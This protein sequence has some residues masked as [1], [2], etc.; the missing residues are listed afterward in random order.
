MAFFDWASPMLQAKPRE[1]DLAALGFAN[2]RYIHWQLGN[3]TLLQR[4]YTPV[5]QAFLLWGLI[6]LVIFL[7]AQFSTLDW[8]TQAALDTSL[9][10]L[11]TLA[12]LHLSHDWSKREGVLWMGW[13]WAGLMA[14]GTVLTDWAVIQAWGWVLVNLCELWL[15]LCAVGYGISGWGMRSRAL[16]LTGAV[17]GGAIGVLPWC[18]SW[19]F[20]ATG[21]VFGISLGVLAE[22][23]WDMCL[24]SGPVLR[25]LA[26]ALDY[27]RDHACEP[28]LDCA[29]E[30]LPC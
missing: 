19:Q 1:L 25:P 12:M 18:G 4:I 28:A 17:H 29:L 3:L 10:L 16:L 20:L 15:G 7:T 6:C 24:G 14:I 2:I 22:L 27:T 26:P 21:L 13:V 11:G 23:R 9:T 30:H 8:L 5:D